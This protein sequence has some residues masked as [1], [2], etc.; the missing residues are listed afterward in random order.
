MGDIKEKKI[1]EKCVAEEGVQIGGMMGSSFSRVYF[2]GASLDFERSFSR[3][4][5]LAGVMLV[6]FLVCVFF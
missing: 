3:G 1:P 4:R 2:L 6:R 5:F